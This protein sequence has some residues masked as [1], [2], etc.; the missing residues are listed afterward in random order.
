MTEENLPSTET[1]AKPIAKGHVFS[2]LQSFEDAQRMVKALTSSNIVPKDYQGPNGVGNALIA[3][4]MSQRIGA[5]PMAVMQNL[6]IIHGKPS[7]SSQFI[8]AALNSC[9]LFSPLR[10]EDNGESCYAWAYDKDTGDKLTGPPV[11]MAM[12]KSEGWIDKSGSKWKTMPDLM[13]RYRSAAFF[14]RLYAPHILVG[15]HSTDEHE[16]IAKEKIVTPATSKLSDIAEKMATEP[17]PVEGEVIPAE[18]FD[19]HNSL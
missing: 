2:S 19:D 17:K 5:S 3:L 9:G 10:F 18:N 14:G 4:E 12:A 13:R 7:W 16:D 15:M 6:Y 8:I 11:S 1:Q